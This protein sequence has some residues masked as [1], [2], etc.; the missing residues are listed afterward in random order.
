MEHGVASLIDIGDVSVFDVIIVPIVFDSFDGVVDGKAVVPD[1]NHFDRGFHVAVVVLVIDGAVATVNRFPGTCFF[2][3]F[4]FGDTV[5]GKEG[6]EVLEAG[7]A[8]LDDDVVVV[9]WSIHDVQKLE[10]ELNIRSK[11]LIC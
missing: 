6:E 2:G 8:G 7:L 3:Y 5:L 9:V 10:S 1:V 11:V 4:E